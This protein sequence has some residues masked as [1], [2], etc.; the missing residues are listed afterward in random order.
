MDFLNYFNKL[1]FFKIP[2]NDFCLSE[3]CFF[4]DSDLIDDKYFICNFIKNN[5]KLNS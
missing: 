3:Y 2:E 4:T 1:S 5:T